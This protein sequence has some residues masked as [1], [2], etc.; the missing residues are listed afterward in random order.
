MIH[1]TI[2]PEFYC[3][4]SKEKTE[5]ALISLGADE[6]SKILEE[7][8]SANLHCH[9]CNTSYNFD[10]DDMRVLIGGLS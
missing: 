3:N 5:K 9:F 1:E 7:D 6:L 2:H 8:K 4:C 10:E